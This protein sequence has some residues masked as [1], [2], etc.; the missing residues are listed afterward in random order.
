MT[1]SFVLLLHSCMSSALF[2]YKHLNGAAGKVGLYFQ[3][4]DILDGA[5]DN[6]I[7]SARRGAYWASPGTVLE[8]IQ[9]RYGFDFT[10]GLPE[11]TVSLDG[12]LHL[13]A[14]P[15]TPSWQRLWILDMD[16][17]RR[18]DE[19]RVVIREAVVLL[20]RHI[21]AIVTSEHPEIVIPLFGAGGQR[22][23]VNKVIGV[24]LPAVIEWARR[25]KYLRRIDIYSNRLQQ[26][27]ALNM[28]I[29]AQFCAVESEDEGFYQAAKDDL[30]QLYVEV[31]SRNDVL[32]EVIREIVSIVD[33][34]AVSAISVLALGRNYCEMYAIREYERLIGPKPANTTLQVMLKALGPHLSKER[35]PVLSYMRLLHSLGNVADHIALQ[36]TYR[37]SHHDITACVMAII[38][39]ENHLQDGA[40]GR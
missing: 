32:V 29:D 6:L 13:I 35:A 39:L 23:D 1:T 8:S 10:E 30:E 33:Q 24:L 15:S 4:A 36:Q 25:A 9:Q 37:L 27:A 34:P 12:G 20:T 19:V 3:A 16:A 31:C 38:R 17:A 7:I 2:N 28:A 11:G 5:S 26:I 14:V 18:Q 40:S 22:Y 21:G